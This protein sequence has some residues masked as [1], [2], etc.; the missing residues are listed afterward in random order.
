ME[1]K[2]TIMNIDKELQE[3]RERFE[4]T[5][6]DAKNAVLIKNYNEAVKQM[7]QYDSLYTEES[8]KNIGAISS[9][10]N[11]ADIK[12]YDIYKEST[13]LSSI[14]EVTRKDVTNKYF[15]DWFFKIMKMDYFAD[16]DPDKYPYS[17]I[18]HSD[19]ISVCGYFNDDKLNGI[20]RVDEYDNYYYL[21]FFFV[22]KS[23]QHRG[24][25]QYLFQS[26]LRRF[27][28]KRLMLEVYTDNSP[29]I[30]IYKKYGFTITGIDYGKGYKPQSP[31][32]IMQKN[33]R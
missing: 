12:T 18:T 24:I 29:A 1:R 17:M 21:S 32:Y 19:E 4:Q 8:I 6:E 16:I 11:E 33:P 20:I 27:R 23:L 2:N 15:K 30:H 7:A 9:V 14:R 22:N 25:G 3:I 13:E 5:I 26:V 10:F 31:H 28:D